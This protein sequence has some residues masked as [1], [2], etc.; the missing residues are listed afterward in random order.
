MHGLRE[1]E[2][3]FLPAKELQQLRAELDLEALLELCRRDRSHGH[4]R[5]T[6]FAP[7]RENASGRLAQ[8][9]PRD[10]ALA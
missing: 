1:R 7:T 10:V 4:E 5:G 9:H 8:L 3:P 6:L 2:V